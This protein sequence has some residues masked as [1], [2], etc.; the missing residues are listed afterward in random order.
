VQAVFHSKNASAV[1]VDVK[2][3]Q[4]E[5]QF[6]D[7]N[8]WQYVKVNDILEVSYPAKNQALLILEDGTLLIKAPNIRGTLNHFLG[9]F[10]EKLSQSERWMKRGLAPLFLVGCFLLAS[11]LL[12]Y[13]FMLPWIADRA[14]MNFPKEQEIAL[15][16]E[17]KKQYLLS[18]R[19]D[20]QQTRLLNEFASKLDLG[21]DFPADY[22]VVDA[23]IVNAY[24]LPG[25]PIVVYAGI[26]RKMQSPEELAGILAHE[27]SHVLRHHSTRSIFQNVSGVLLLN[28]VLGDASSFINL[29]AQNGQQ[30]QQLSYSRELELEADREGLQ[31]LLKNNINPDGMLSLL[32]KL[33]DEN[34]GSIFPE[35]LSTHPLPDSRIEALKKLLVNHSVKTTH[36][37][38]NSIWLKLK[39][40]K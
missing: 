21:N 1:E 4:G 22:T 11:I 37:D 18:E 30:I 5:I 8:S 16:A 19:I 33:K 29:I 32:E 10:N 9:S 2:I 34:S 36:S 13:F 7:L 35:F 31:L 24:A 20:T 40:V 6:Y 27:R 23:D 39:S 25:G 14:A 28:L 12:I 3:V 17:L 26:I 15:G 38:I